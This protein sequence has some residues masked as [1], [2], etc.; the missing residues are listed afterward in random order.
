[1]K[2]ES[3]DSGNVRVVN[4]ALIS[5]SQVTLSTSGHC[6]KLHAKSTIVVCGLLQT[7]D[8]DSLSKQQAKS[9]EKR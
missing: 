1:M 7:N 9:N 2:C 5:K 3:L 8:N 6:E 4:Q